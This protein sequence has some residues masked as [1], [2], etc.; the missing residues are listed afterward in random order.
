[1]FEQLENNQ[2]S[3]KSIN[4]GET[5]AKIEFSEQFEFLVS[6]LCEWKLDVENHII[7]RGGGQADQTQDLTEKFNARGWQKNRITVQNSITFETKYDARSSDSTSHEIDHI[8]ENSNQRLMALEIEWN[9]KDEFFDRDFQAMRRLY[10]L[11]IIDLGVILTRGP[12]LEDQLKGVISSYFRRESINDFADFER[13][14]EKFSDTQGNSRFSFPTDAQKNQ[15]RVKLRRGDSFE[16]ASAEVFKTN[17][18]GGTTTNWRQLD[19]RIERRDAG[20]TPMLFL[21]MPP[22]QQV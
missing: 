20:R 9:N 5:I 15:I 11:D 18:Y 2:W 3:V 13:L 12:E 22:I 6:A 7:K 17:K 16:I 1:L 14:V 4:H 10:E 21:G 19:Y 8:I